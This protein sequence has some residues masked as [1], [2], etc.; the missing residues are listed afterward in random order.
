MDHEVPLAPPTRR[1]EADRKALAQLIAA[2]A[3]LVGALACSAQLVICRLCNA[4][5]VMHHAVHRCHHPGTRVL[6]EHL[7]GRHFAGGS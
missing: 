3:K 7:Q 6:T 5:Q 1:L 4:A 2:V